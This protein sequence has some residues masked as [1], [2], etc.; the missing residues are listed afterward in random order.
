MANL[1]TLMG[2]ILVDNTKAD[3]SIAKSAAKAVDF[4]N[5]LV[6]AAKTAAKLGAAAAG[7]AVA[8]GAAVTKI[9]DDTREYRNEMGKLETAF[10]DS[11]FSAE[12]AK[13]TYRSL[14]GI[15]GETDQ[16]VEAANHLAEL[17]D[18]EKALSDW[19]DIC[20]GVYA[21]FGA[22]LPVEGLTEAAN[23]TAKVGQV[24]GPLADA[25]NWVGLSAEDLGLKLKANTDANKEWNDAINNGAAA[26]DLFNMA[27]S[28]C[29]TEQ[30]RQALITQTLN[31]L[32]SETGKKYRE[33]N[34]DVIAA[35][36]AN[37]KLNETM[38]K[39]GEIF[40]P[41]LTDF[42]IYG[43][44]LLDSVIPAIADFVAEHDIAAAAIGFVQDAIDFLI[45]GYDRLVE[46]VK[47]VIAAVQDAVEWCKEHKTMLEI[48]AVAMAG[49]TAALIAYNAASIAKK[50]SSIAE[51][52]A[53]YALIVAEEL[54]TV[55]TG[56][57]TAAT[58]AFGA[59]VSFL[60]SPIT[61]AI[62]A[63]TALIAIGVLLYK[64]WDVV[65][66]KCS[67]C[68]SNLK[69]I[70]GDIKVAISEKIE[71]IVSE[72]SEKFQMIKEKAI[73]IFRNMSQALADIWQNTKNVVQF[74]L[75]FIAELISAAFQLITLPW[76]FIWQNCKEYI[77]AAWNFMKE[78]V[79]NSLQ[80]I[81]NLISKIWNSIV[82]VLS[83]ILSKIQNLVSSAWNFAKS[84]TSSI[85]SSVK[86]VISNIWNSCKTV[87][88]KTVENIKSVISKGF[89]AA[90]NV[91]ENIVS[92]IKSV[93]SKGFQAAKNTVANIM[94]SIKSEISN[95]W[96]LCKSIVQNAIN[97]IKSVISK[98]LNSAKSTV[99]NILSSMKSKFTSIFDG[100]KSTVK[101]AIEKIKGYFKFSWSLPKLKL[102]HISISGS[103]SLT[104]KPQVPKFSI[105]WYRKAYDNAMILN[106]PTL[107]GYDAA[108]GNLLGG[109]DGPE[110]EIVSGKSTLMD[111]IRGAVS[112]EN[113]VL[114]Q[115]IDH[116]ISLLSRF[117]PKVLQEM[118][119]YIVLE[120]G[121]IDVLV[122]KL[123]PGI[124][125]K[126][127]AESDK[128]E[129]RS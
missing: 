87:I 68:W 99:S 26:E 27:L 107:F 66:E 11:N 93:I 38:A 6:S 126:L 85:F 77:I 45:D 54:H 29:S 31:D 21:K 49:L 116:L 17:C 128:S 80:S 112:A 89:Q 10:E 70:W 57:A 48:I 65:K 88:A 86:S 92:S 122:G 72:I 67:E 102:P 69:E 39:I 118:G 50:A 90:K 73:E 82:G 3:S 71:S 7:M 63:I 46:G 2:T 47:D 59:A 20:A 120:D 124:N 36:E 97:N 109:G 76:Q 75:L 43:A 58:T 106:K 125:K 53:I 113:S 14:Q 18:S 15:L 83:P 16:A 114:V 98:G 96:N 55:T 121:F 62:A 42:K 101:N 23:E 81:K 119:R 1:F 32:Y 44:T 123:T 34:K 115:R 12:T 79:S 103:F 64:N 28:E 5:K 100:V 60:T 78:W 51:T 33:N 84:E 108:S 129:R 41:V 52:V 22:S 104:P 13:N 9:T 25:L 110:E 56:I 95:K 94:S 91:V 30:E 111:M 37:E 35:N 4:A 24:T 61:I 117:F 19:T 40:E 127:G 8:V 74:A 105:E